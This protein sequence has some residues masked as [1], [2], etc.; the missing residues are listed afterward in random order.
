MLCL[1]SSIGVQ[2]SGSR[3]ETYLNGGI[4]AREH[5]NPVQGF[6]HHVPH[7]LMPQHEGQL[8]EELQTTAQT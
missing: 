8:V 3:G 2:G 7:A 5:G 4:K 1:E 6:G